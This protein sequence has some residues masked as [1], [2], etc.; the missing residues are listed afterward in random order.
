MDAPDF[1]HIE[2]GDNASPCTVIYLHGRGSREDEVYPI[3]HAFDGTRLISC[4][5]RLVQHP[6]FAWFRN[7]GIGVADPISIEREKTA[8][9]AWL[10]DAVTSDE[11]WL[12]GFSNGAAMAAALMLTQ[13]EKFRGLIMVGG[14]FAEDR[15]PEDSLL[16]KPVLFCRGLLD[17]VIPEPKFS[18]SIL[19][20]ENTS[21][22]DLTR[23]DYDAGHWIPRELV[24]Q[25]GNWFTSLRGN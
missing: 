9:F 20:L 16:G 3:Q 25:I 10:E 1:T 22:A 17:N 4:R 12:C 11:T 2:L 7:H 15:F 21:G 13:P 24:T 18:Q 6:G 5:A 23:I 8:L 19:Y 14:C